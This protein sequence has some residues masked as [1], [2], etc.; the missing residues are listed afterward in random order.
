[1]QERSEDAATGDGVDRGDGAEAFEPG[2]AEK[3]HQ[4][5]FGLVVEGV[6]GEDSIGVAPRDERSKGFIA[7]VAGSFFEGLF[8]G[9]GVG[10]GIDARDVEGNLQEVAEGL[11]ESLVRVGFFSS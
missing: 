8:V 3:L 4:D 7:Q 6:S 9:G 11:D 10:G 2:S 1:M 5:G